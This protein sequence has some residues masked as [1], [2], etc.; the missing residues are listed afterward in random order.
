MTPQEPAA[1]PNTHVFVVE[2]LPLAGE[3]NKCLGE[4]SGPVEIEQVETWVHLA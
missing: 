1:G 2:V 4:K 3:E